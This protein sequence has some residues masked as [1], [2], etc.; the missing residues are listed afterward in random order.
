MEEQKGGDDEHQRDKRKQGHDGRAKGGWSEWR[1][2]LE[3]SLA[4]LD[5]EEA[6]HRDGHRD[7]DASA[8]GERDSDADGQRRDEYGHWG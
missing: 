8:Q 5:K 4:R 2:V 7:S 3:E 1:S 6:A